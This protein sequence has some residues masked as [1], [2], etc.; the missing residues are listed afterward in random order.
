MLCLICALF[1]VIIAKSF[2]FN[3]IKERVFVFTLEN[4][5]KFL[6]LE[7]HSVPIVSFVIHVDVGTCDEQVGIYGITHFLEHMAFKGTHEIGTTNYKLETVILDQMDELFR[8]I[9]TEKNKIRPDADFIQKLEKE[10]LKLQKDAG[11]YGVPNEFDILLEA[12]GATGI[13]A[14]TGADKT[15]Y[16]Y[17]FPANKIEL[18]AYM[19]SSR[20][21]NPVFREFY[22]EREVIREE[23][24]SRIEN[25]SMGILREEILA[26]SYKF[27][28]YGIIGI[29]PMSDI[30]TITRQDLIQYFKKYYH[31]KNMIIGVSG[32]VNPAALKKLANKYFSKIPGKLAM[33]RM[34]T[35]EPGQLGERQMTIALDSQPIL[36]IACHMP[37]ADHEDFMVFNLLDYI[38]SNGRSSRL[39]KKMVTQNQIALT[40]VS[41]T[42]FPGDKYPS[43]FL[44]YALPNQGH[45]NTELKTAVFT[46]IEALKKHPIP[47]AEL[48]S[49]K[50]RMKTDLIRQM[51]NEKYFIGQLISDEIRYGDWQKTF[52][53]FEWLDKIT[54]DHVRRVVQDYFTPGNRNLIFIE[55]KKETKR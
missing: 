42:G 35:K 55:T 41:T 5:L 52:K 6:L 37:A 21:I 19:E 12:Q 7:D 49:A 14:G 10:L 17:S 4:G 26:L 39:Y 18:W 48:D 44:I 46:E 25:S 33:Q 9:Q 54:P 23:R 30:E 8:Q 38:L 28:P 16:Y 47:E 20:F 53:D 31:A 43:L 1:Q 45:A 13:N 22:K 24:R 29:G 27:H 11:L 34:T 51:N 32:D 15:I 36:A 3:S 50:V 2:D 40:V